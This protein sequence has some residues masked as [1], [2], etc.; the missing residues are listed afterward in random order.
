MP[1]AGDD[2]GDMIRP[3]HELH[4]TPVA[5]W[6][7][8]EAFSHLAATVDAAARQHPDLME[9]YLIRVAD[10]EPDEQMQVA[11]M[12][13]AL[14]DTFWRRHPSAVARPADESMSEAG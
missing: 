9:P 8:D 5:Q 10:A 13:E 12:R 11:I 14:R 7:R 3:D 1:V 6:T 4:D 2:E